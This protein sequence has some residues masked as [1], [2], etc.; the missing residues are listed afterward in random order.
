MIHNGLNTHQ[1]H[2]PATQSAQHELRF[3]SLFDPGRGLVVPCDE[4]GVVDLDALTEKQ[5]NHYLGA[6]ALVGRQYA[7]P[8]IEDVRDVRH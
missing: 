1:T 6:R 7:Y 3:C 8:V 2:H 4:H 5:R